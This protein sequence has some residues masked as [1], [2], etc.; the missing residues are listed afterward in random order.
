MEDDECENA[1]EG[2]RRERVDHKDRCRYD[3]N[4]PERHAK[5]AK[6]LAE[7]RGSE[8]GYPEGN[9]TYR[10]E[11]E[12]YAKQRI[13][14]SLS[15]L[16]HED[17]GRLIFGSRPRSMIEVRDRGLSNMR[18]SPGSQYAET[19]DAHNTPEEGGREARPPKSTIQ[20]KEVGDP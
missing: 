13:E 4:R 11:E 12:P 5:P 8:H 9:E 19:H 17:E 15:R 3:P 14:Y 20:G 6:A 10:H 1:N 16:P 18:E 2:A 7:G